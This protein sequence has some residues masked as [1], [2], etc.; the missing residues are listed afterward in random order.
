M[1]NPGGYNQGWGG[2]PSW[3]SGGGGGGWG[4]PWGNDMGG[5]EE[6][7]K[8]M[9]A[10]QEFYGGYGQE[11]EPVPDP[12]PDPV[13][14]PAPGLNDDGNPVTPAIP[15]PTVTLPPANQPRGPRNPSGPETPETPGDPAAPTA[16]TAPQDPFG[17]DLSHDWRNDPAYSDAFRGGV[18]DAQYGTVQTSQPTQ[19]TQPSNPGANVAQQLSQMYPR[20]GRRMGSPSR[21]YNPGMGPQN[22][23]AEGYGREGGNTPNLK[24]NSGGT[25]WS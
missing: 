16:P 19:P 24:L 4:M 5:F 7:M 2:S 18:T 15:D 14:D 1:V 17:N 3:G 20:L 8:M 12:V 6:Y 11:E 13:S 25:P 21:E 22:G 9:Q 10:W 23:L